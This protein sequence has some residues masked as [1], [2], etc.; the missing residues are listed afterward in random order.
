MLEIERKFSVKCTNFLANIKESYKITQGYLNSDKNRTVRVRTKGT[1]G[2]ITIKGLGSDSG[3]SRFEW[4]KE[5]SL[6]EAESLLLLCEGFII[7]KVRYIVPF[8]DVVFEVDVFEGTNKGLIIAEV[9]LT[10]ETQIFNKPDWLGDELTQDERFYNAYL[11]NNP[12]T[13]WNH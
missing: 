7:D 11:S 3:M 1:K 4:E 6:K 2:F 9:E 13:S 12:F 5:I 10:S 8:D